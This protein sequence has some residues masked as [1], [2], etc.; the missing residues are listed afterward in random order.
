ML[1]KEGVIPAKAGIHASRPGMAHR[2]IPAF[3]RMTNRGWRR[4][5]LL[6]SMALL[7]LMITSPAHAV[8]PDEMLTDPALEAR[9]REVG[10]ELRC[11]VCRNQSI[12]DSAADRAQ[13]L[14]V[15]VRGAIGPRRSCARSASESSIDWLR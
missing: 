9:A 5:V 2:W 15:R 13:D 6:L 12:A 8:R 3:A 7:A 14:R 4:G 1:K 11:L 10:Q